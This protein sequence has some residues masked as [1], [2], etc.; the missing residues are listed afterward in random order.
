MAETA[1][2]GRGCNSTTQADEGNL[3]VAGA[4]VDCENVGLRS[5]DLLLLYCF[6]SFPSRTMESM[7]FEKVDMGGGNHSLSIF[8]TPKILT[9]HILQ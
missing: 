3:Q 6:P 4:E 1:V 5:H 2:R 8:T 7:N 9:H